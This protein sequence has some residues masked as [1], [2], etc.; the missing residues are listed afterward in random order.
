MANQSKIVVGGVVPDEQTRVEILS[1]MRALYGADRVSDELEVGNVVAPANWDQYVLKMIDPNLK[2]ISKGEIRVDGNQIHLSGEVANE[3]QRQT[4]TSNLASA[5]NKTYKLNNAL[6]LRSEQKSLDD[7][8]ANRTVEFQSG[9][10]ILTTRG[11]VVLDEMARAI[12]QLGG[13]RIAIIGNTDDVGNRD[14]NIE[15]SLARAS[16]VRQ[17]LIG[18]RIE[19]GMLSVTGNGPDYPIADNATAEG[20]SK[21]RRIDFKILN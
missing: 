13:A 4:V 19:S 5:F 15:L 6:Q 16:A 20:R 18:K 9:S 8:L 11:R 7:T 3:A 21:N 14:S 1:R 12:Q 10:A 2:Q 17:Y